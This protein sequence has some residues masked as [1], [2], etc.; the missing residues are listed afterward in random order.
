MD[1]VFKY[2]NIPV[3]LYNFNGEIFYKDDPLKLAIKRRVYT[4]TGVVKNHHLYLLNGNLASLRQQPELKTFEFKASGNYYISDR[5]EPVEFKAINYIDNILQLAEHSEYNLIHLDND[6]VGLVHHLIQSGYEP[7]VKWNAGIVSE[8]RVRFGYKDLS[9]TVTYNII[10][11]NLSRAVM[12]GEV[13][14]DTAET[15]NKIQIKMLKFNHA[16]FLW[17]PH[18]SIQWYWFTILKRIQDH[19]SNGVF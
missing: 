17:K 8:I 9:K 15:Y 7:L 6:M 5:T 2:F 16:M 19:C 4:F 3:R 10:S 12:Q 14:M 11:Q 13:I 1:R 18:V